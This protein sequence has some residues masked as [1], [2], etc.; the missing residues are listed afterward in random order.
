MEELDAK[1]TEE[2]LSKAIEN[3]DAEK[4]QGSDEIHPDLMNQR[5]SFLL[6]PLH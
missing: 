3:L 4:D 5:K 6:L 2:E 1:P